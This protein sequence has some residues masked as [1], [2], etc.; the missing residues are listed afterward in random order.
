MGGAFNVALLLR[1]A[2]PGEG[3]LGT[4]AR[5]GRAMTDADLAMIRAA[6]ADC[7]GGLARTLLGEPN[8]DTSTKT[9]LRFG[10]NKGSLAVKLSGPKAGRFFENSTQEGGDMLA[11]I[12]RERRCTFREAINFAR[13]FCSLRI[14]VPRAVARPEQDR[15]RR[16]DAMDAA[17]DIWRGSVDPRGAVVERYLASRGLPLLDELA[18][19][20]L[21]FHAALRF[22]GRNVP[23]MVALLRDIWSECACGIIRTF[24]DDQGH[25]IMR[26][27]LGR[28]GRA[29]VKLDA[30][31]NVTEGLH[32]CE[33]VE[34][35]I[36]AM[37]AG[38]RPVWAL[39]SAGAIAKFPVLG[40][41]DAL[42]ILTETN[43]GGANARAVTEVSARW[44]E[45]GRE[46]LTVEMLVG[47]DFNDAWR[48][49]AP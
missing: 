36:A 18:G 10:R 6:L 28:A 46:V 13:E 5:E 43:D 30:D 41:I 21:R 15:Q 35:G 23:T 38:Y 32:V 4:A 40:G 22:D 17:S 11:L 26:K 37:V 44:H 42:T 2:R 31:A 49:A 19:D 34:T 20:V 7:A 45:A 24:F 48:E 29:A 25:K 14:I 33:G 9:E 12:M 47:G 3:L 8:R 27:M 1:Q 16:M 39:G